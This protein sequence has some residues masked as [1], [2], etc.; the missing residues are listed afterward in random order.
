MNVFQPSDLENLFDY[1]KG[2]RLST[3]YADNTGGVGLHFEGGVDDHA[4]TIFI[5]PGLEPDSSPCLTI[6]LIKQS[7]FDMFWK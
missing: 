4:G 7:A 6:H 2:A 1:L 3:L 5:S